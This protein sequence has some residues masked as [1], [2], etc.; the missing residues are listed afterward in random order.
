MCTL[1]KE[2]ERDR[3]KKGNSIRTS[4]WRIESVTF[5]FFF[6]RLY[7]F[8]MHAMYAWSSYADQFMIKEIYRSSQ[9]LFSIN[10]INFDLSWKYIK[11]RNNIRISLVEIESTRKISL[12]YVEVIF[13][14]KYRI[15]YLYA[16]NICQLKIEYRQFCQIF[17]SRKAKGNSFLSSINI[18]WSLF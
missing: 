2:N 11:K 17:A 6:F 14:V 1:V 8:F 9:I 3:E 5:H 7:L 4:N 15:G 13:H 16:H 12:N 18:L 10:L